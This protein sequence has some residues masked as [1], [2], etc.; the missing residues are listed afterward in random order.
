M[1]SCSSFKY[2]KQHKQIPARKRVVTS[3]VKLYHLKLWESHQGTD[4]ITELI[5]DRGQPQT[6]VSP[7]SS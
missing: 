4:L 2:Y 5:T 3:N 7:L 6:Q 1:Y